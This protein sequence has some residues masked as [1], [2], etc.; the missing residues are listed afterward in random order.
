MTTGQLPSVATEH[1][2]RV[3]FRSQRE[4]I[5]V[6]DLPVEGSVPA[7]L[8]GTLVRNGP[9]N[10]EVGDRRVNHWFDGQAMLHRFAFADGHVSYANRFLETRARRAAAEGKRIT[11][12]EFATDPCRSLFQRA[13]A[14]F[15]P[16]FS[17]N[18]SVNVVRLGERFLAMTETPLPVAFDPATLQTLGVVEYED[19]IGAGATTAHPHLDPVTGDLVNYVASFGRKNAYN[20][21]AQTPGSKTRRVIASIPVKEPGYMHSFAITERYV[22]LVEHPIVVNPIKIVLSGRPFIENYRWEPERG[23]RYLVVDKAAGELRSIHHGPANFIFHHVNA[24]EEGE[25]I[26]M[27]ASVYEDAGIISSLYLDELL[28]A[29]GD[30]PRARLTRTRLGAGGVSS[31]TIGEQTIELPRINYKRHNGRPYRYVY[32]DSSSTGRNFLD[33]LLKVDVQ[34][35]EETIW[36]EENHYP[37]EPVFVAAPDARAEDEGVVLSVVL[38]AD[39]GTSYLLVLDAQ[40]FE[41]R[42]RARVPQ[43]VPYG[44]HG[45]YFH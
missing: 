28:A 37:G 27:D 14:L 29:R 6:E 25:E 22:V 16:Q 38:D 24:W 42:A 36:R 39:A 9:A 45:A 8:S 7:W 5:A 30:I 41:E 20:V 13:A 18:A 10:Y 31:E 2:Y 43:H 34:T 26:V 23:T 21:Y 15:D 44:F 40:T 32:G 12:G 3:G 33:Q 35:G 1:D 11:Y 4:E 17:D 19:K